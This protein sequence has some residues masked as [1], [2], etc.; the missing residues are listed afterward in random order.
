VADIADAVMLKRLFDV[1]LDRG[2]L[3]VATS[4]RHPTE[5]Y[6]GIS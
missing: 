3:L 2:L 1:L 6:Q 4:N 5:L